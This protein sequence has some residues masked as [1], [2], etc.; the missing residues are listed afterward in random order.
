MQ[1]PVFN[2]WTSHLCKLICMKY[3]YKNVKTNQKNT[4]TLPGSQSL[5]SHCIYQ[6]PVPMVTDRLFFDECNMEKLKSYSENRSRQIQGK[7][8]TY[9]LFCLTTFHEDFDQI[10][11]NRFVLNIYIVC[12]FCWCSSDAEYNLA[13]VYKRPKPFIPVSA[14][15]DTLQAKFLYSLGGKGL[16]FTFL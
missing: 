11:L 2:L 6:F 14:E 16:H 13:A 9:V 7:R 8:C 4:H 10:M 5:H 15:L 3:M 1:R 12:D